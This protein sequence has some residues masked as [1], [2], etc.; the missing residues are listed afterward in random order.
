M[1]QVRTPRAWYAVD[2]NGQRNSSKA[3]KA[4]PL[5]VC[6]TVGCATGRAD[7]AFSKGGRSGAGDPGR[8]AGVAGVAVVAASAGGQVA[9]A[10]SAKLLAEAEQAVQAAQRE[11]SVATLARRP[12]R[13]LAEL[14]LKKAL[15]ADVAMT[16]PLGFPAW[17]MGELSASQATHCA[18]LDCEHGSGLRKPLALSK[19]FLVSF[20]HCTQSVEAA[21]H[22]LM[23]MML[24]RP[25]LLPSNKDLAHPALVRLVISVKL[26]KKTMTVPPRWSLCERCC[27]N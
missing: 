18:E 4:G 3:D 16:L 6:S 21:W 5:G 13:R 2:G 23:P 26:E 12:P 11:G 8:V 20:A 17:S 10:A 7:R 22:G 19:S 27:W 9:L 24:G 15:V 14:V 25:S 1:L